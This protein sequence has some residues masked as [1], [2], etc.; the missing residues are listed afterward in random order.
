MMRE[1]A[2]YIFFVV[3]AFGAMALAIAKKISN[4]LTIIFLIFSLF[5][6]ALMTNINSIA[7]LKWSGFEIEN[8]QRDVTNI[9][10]S[11]LDDFKKQIEIQIGIQKKS[12]GDLIS[13]SEDTQKKL[14][15]QSDKLNRLTKED[16]KTAHSLSEDTKS[17]LALKELLNYV[18]L[19]L[20]A[21]S[22]DIKQTA[23][24]L[25]GKPKGTAEIW[26]PEDDMESNFFA[27]KI[28]SALS[29]AE[30]NVTF[31][32][33]IPYAEIKDQN[34]LF[35]VKNHTTGLAVLGKR[36]CR[37]GTGENSAICALREALMQQEAMR[38]GLVMATNT[39]LADN[40]FLIIVFRNPGLSFDFQP[41]QPDVTP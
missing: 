23:N 29:R 27:D 21:R 18:T 3:V 13:R 19:K 11:T 4:T 35:Y 8:F 32:K 25:K 16:E 22:L 31:P 24:I 2:T 17:L 6:L 15:V 20:R 28:Q 36:L 41:S 30:W 10:N 39:G 7:K 14:Q 26:Y 1:V 9:K 5:A 33:T 40:Y 34:I 12:I 38:H 37:V